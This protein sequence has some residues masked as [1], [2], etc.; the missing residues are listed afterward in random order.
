MKTHLLVI[1]NMFVFGSFGQTNEIP[2]HIF[3]GTN[4]VL[5]PIQLEGHARGELKKRGFDVPS[6]ARC[7]INLTLK[8]TNSACYVRLS[9]G[10]KSFQLDLDANGR[11]LNA[12]SLMSRAVDEYTLTPEEKALIIREVERDS[13]KSGAS[14]ESDPHKKQ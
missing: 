5:S 9:K 11:V 7:S 8:S 4:I 6:D 14:G 10:S 1:I 12:R 13:V 3:F 2:I